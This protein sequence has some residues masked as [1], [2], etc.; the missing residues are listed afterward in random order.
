MLSN[1]YYYRVVGSPSFLRCD[2]GRVELLFLRNA[3]SMIECLLAT[4]ESFERQDMS[5]SRQRYLGKAKAGSSSTSLERALDAVQWHQDHETF[6]ESK[7]QH[8]TFDQ[9]TR[10]SQAVYVRIRAEYSLR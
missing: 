6:I 8:S 5:V 10:F 4:R 1:I 9:T 3:G 2:G 7:V